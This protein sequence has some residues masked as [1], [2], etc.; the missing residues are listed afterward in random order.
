MS[1][2]LLTTLS[3]LACSFALV[4]SASASVPPAT[5]DTF[6]ITNPIIAP[7]DTTGLLA[8]SSIIDLGFSGAVAV[9]LD[10]VDVNSSLVKQIY[11]SGS[12]TN[13][14]P[15]SWDGKN[16]FSNF[17]DNGIYTVRVV[18]TSA[19]VTA[20]DTTKTI[21]VANPVPDIEAPVITILGS[22]PLDINVGDLYVDAGATAT[23]DVDGP[24][25]VV[26]TGTVDVLTVGAY[27]ILYTATDAAT[28]MAT[29]S[30]TVNVKAKIITEATSTPSHRGGQGY[31]PGWGP[32]GYMGSVAPGQVLGTST[33][34]IAKKVVVK[35]ELT[36][37]EKKARELRGKLNHIKI[38][39]YDLKHPQSQVLS[40]GNPSSVGSV[41]LVSTDLTVSV[42][43]SGE[44]LG[45]GTKAT[46]TAK[47]P[48]WKFW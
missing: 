17:V 36:P 38:A 33:D 35:Q 1:K 26:A 44:I 43:D 12:V 48:W 23:D 29:T 30:R 6:T 14:T 42:S 7:T 8:T 37:E 13:P 11:D 45:T 46:S 41:P 25:S 5:L 32:N 39:I 15:K 10:I 16:S 22:N 31:A 28:N 3:L 9:N 47:K 27:S 21:T 4:L 24:V 34:K 18:Y 2:K 40:I 20:T 19:G